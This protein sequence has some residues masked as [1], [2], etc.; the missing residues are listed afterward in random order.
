MGS[1]SVGSRSKRKEGRIAGEGG[2]REC[3]CGG[4]L[5]VVLDSIC[6]LCPVCH[7]GLDVT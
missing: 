7:R 6:T 1:D 3:F 4:S 5:R 2:Q